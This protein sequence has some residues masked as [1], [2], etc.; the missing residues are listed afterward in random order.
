MKWFEV[1]E[2]L[3]YATT[4]RRFRTKE[5]AEKYVAM[6]EEWCYSGIGEVDTESS[7]FFD[8]VDEEEK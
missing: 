8:T 6:N 7:W 3:C 2:D 5:E 1:V 4:T